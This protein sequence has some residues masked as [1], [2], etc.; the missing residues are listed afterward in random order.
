MVF[1]D[2]LYTAVSGIMKLIQKEAAEIVSKEWDALV[3][4]SEQGNPF[5]LYSWISAV[6]PKW[7]ALFV[8]DGGKIIAFMPL[9]L[10]KK[11]FWYFA[12]QPLY[13]M[14][15]GPAFCL[16]SESQKIRSLDLIVQTL[17]KQTDYLKYNLSPTFPAGLLLPYPQI[18]RLN[19]I[20]HQA[21]LR[22]DI[23]KNFSD[24]ARRQLKKV[25]KNGYQIEKTL[26]LNIVRT[27]FQDNPQIIHAKEL[28]QMI[29]LLESQIH[30]GIA[31]IL[32]GKDPTGEV[33]ACGIFVNYKQTRY[34]LA[35]AVKPSHRSSGIMTFI[36]YEAMS[37]GKSEG[38]S[39]FDFEGSSN[40]GIAK[41]FKGL[42][43]RQIS[44]DC[45]QIN[46]LPALLK[47]I[48]R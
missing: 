25:Q 48:K 11:L 13:C 12:Q 9:N 7:K 17:L 15:W 10:K 46:Q 1:I 19:R 6:H 40:P 28:Q 18:E 23:H 21:D 8:E 33:A 43:G 22:E 16:A 26:D 30:T 14:S 35:G 20:T 45:I 34:Y 31:E 32:Y 4:E 42:G 5:M 36:M 29:Y 47:W 41:F 44:Y 3:S 38:F 39:I 37:F 2:R 27:V 24:S